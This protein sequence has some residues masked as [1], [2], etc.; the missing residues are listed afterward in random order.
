MS[1]ETKIGQTIFLT[2]A[3]GIVGT[4]LRPMLRARYRHVILS[5]RRQITDLSANESWKPADLDD[6]AQVSQ[7]MQGT[8]AV[9]HLGGQPNEASWETIVASNI[10]GLRNIYEAARKFGIERVVFASSHHAVGMYGRNR[11]IGSHNQPRPDSLYGVSKVLGEALASYYADKYGLRSLSI[12][13]GNVDTAPRDFRRMSVFLH[14]EDLMQLIVIGLESD[15]VHNQVVYGVSD[16]TRGFWD[17][18]EAFRLGYS[19]QH[20]AEDHVE[21]A[22]QGEAEAPDLE[23][24]A[25]AFQGAAFA[26]A[27]FRGDLERVL[28]P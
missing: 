13:I 4:H 22:T 21:T 10:E 1:A 7:A 17:N 3:S 23:P 2:G 16:N 14:P 8:D 25:L 11:K 28:K 26:A 12:R 18:I 9:V 24:I 6:F 19:P 5:S 27:D 20:R 15:A